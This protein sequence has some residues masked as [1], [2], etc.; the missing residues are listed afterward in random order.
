MRTK[1]VKAGAAIATATLLLLVTS[2]GPGLAVR[3]RAAPAA[4]G[5]TAISAW[6]EGVRAGTTAFT[7]A[8]GATCRPKVGTTAA[9][10]RCKI[11]Y[12]GRFTATDRG[13]RGTYSGSAFITYLDPATD[14]YAAFDNG[15]I[16]YKI[17]DNDGNWLGKRVL[18][19]DSGT[20]GIFGFPY[21]LSIRYT[22]EER[23]EHDTLV[24]RMSGV[25]VNALGNRLQPVRRFIDRIRYQSGI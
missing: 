25:G 18:Y 8:T 22:V 4:A 12:S 21:D 15:T 23:N 1:T 6:Y 14:N 17:W 24:L 5:E 3:P 10:R 13:Y 19:V 9:D 7:T 20:G 11:V 2:S 16:T